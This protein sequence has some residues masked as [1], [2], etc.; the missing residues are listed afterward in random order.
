MN[1]EIIK[2]RISDMIVNGTV[3]AEVLRNFISS[4]G[5]ILPLESIL[6]DYKLV[7]DSSTNGYKKTLKSIVSLYNTHGGYIIYGIKE[8]KKDTIFQAVGITAEQLDQQKL[9]GQFDKFFGKRISLTYQEIPLTINNS[10]KLFGLLH[11]PKRKLKDHSLAPM[12]DAQD[13]NNKYIFE[14]NAIYYRTEDECKKVV[15]TDDFKFISSKRDFGNHSNERALPKIFIENNLPDRSFICPVFVGRFKILEELWAWLADELQH[16]KVL[17]ADGG[18]GKTSIAYEFCQLLI[19]TK[20]DGIEQIIWLTAKRKQFKAIFDQYIDTP[21]THFNNMETL[22]IEICLRTGSLEHELEDLSVLQLTKLAKGNLINYPSFIV[23]DDVDSNS[24]DEQ[25]RIL[26]VARNISSE[27]SKV[28]LTTRVNSIYS[29]DSSISVPGMFGDEYKVLVHTLCERFN[30]SHLNEKNI[31]K[32]EKASEGSPLFTESILRLFKQGSSIENAIDEWGEKS[33]E[34]VREA[35]LKKEVSE[36]SIDAKKVLVT[37]CTVGSCS[38]TELHQLTDIEY[39]SIGNALQ[40]LDLLFLVNSIPFIESEPRYEASSSIIQLTISMVD[41]LIPE[42]KA[43]LSKISKISYG[44][45]SNSKK[46]HPRV[47]EAVRQCNALIKT[48]RYI[49]AR[50]TLISIIK[51]PE[52]KENKDLFYLAASIEYSDPDSDIKTI[53]NAFQT[54]YIKGQ[55]KLQFFEQWYDFAIQS[56]SNLTTFEICRHAIKAG[57]MNNIWTERY[58]E[59]AE[60]TVQSTLDVKKKI[61]Q[62][63]DA[64][65]QYVNSKQTR[66]YRNN[67]DAFRLKYQKVFE[68]LCQLCDSVKDNKTKAVFVMTTLRSGDISTMVCN[69]L[70]LVSQQ[71][72]TLKETDNSLMDEIFNALSDTKESLEKQDMPR[73]PLISA[74]N[75]ELLEQARTTALT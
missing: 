36:L 51:E 13:E 74:I 28:L 47:G 54:A 61:E 65:I 41:D 56:E 3:S 52:F 2:T 23:I 17:A 26:E 20:V 58:L 12:S 45:Q 11:V 29:I 73:L 5:A 68:R 37:V 16:S 25:K 32:L 33:G 1:I 60:N 71:L 64:Y 62:L 35:A 50:N 39:S 27:K 4:D 21:E 15:S 14:K 30:L 34:A 6:W 66:M 7:F 9:K 67:W 72:R 8:I 53:S 18:K 49:D 59:S 10:E 38:K 46:Y 22:L 44:L 75:D 40:E 57:H 24:P 55:R 63:G 69:Q 43:F 19:T 48:K 70:I 31:N 42:A